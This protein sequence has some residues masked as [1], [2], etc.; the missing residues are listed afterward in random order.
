MECGGQSESDF[1]LKPVFCMPK[2]STE[3]LKWKN[4]FT[5]HFGVTPARF[6]QNETK[7]EERC[8]KY[9][10]VCIEPQLEDSVDTK[11]SRRGDLNKKC[12]AAMDKYD[13]IR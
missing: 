7:L 3:E 6:K 12:K 2:D 10:I 5:N 9:S 1:P 4:K 11:N 13:W 8:K